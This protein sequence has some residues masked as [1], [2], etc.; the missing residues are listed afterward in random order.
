MGSVRSDS[1]TT[2]SP[3][4][5][6]PS[7]TTSSRWFRAETN[8]NIASTSEEGSPTFHAKPVRLLHEGLSM[9]QKVPLWKR[10]GC[11]WHRTKQQDRA[12]TNKNSSASRRA[13]SSLQGDRPPFKMD[14][15]REI[16]R[17]F[18]RLFNYTSFC[19]DLS[20]LSFRDQ[21]K[22]YM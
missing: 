5:T 13:H 11:G 4:S 16:K 6:S 3:S 1:P 10:N 19:N 21:P 7:S 14:N 22:V 9:E 20:S 18:Y 12:E 17:N 15:V 8:E 2:P